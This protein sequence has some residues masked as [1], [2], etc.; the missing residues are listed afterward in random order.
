MVSAQRE[1]P[2]RLEPA[3]EKAVTVAARTVAE[4]CGVRGLARVDF[5][6][7][8]DELFINEINTIPG[9]LTK[10]LWEAP[11]PKLLADML[12]EAVT[13]P[14][15]RYDA[16]GADGLALRSAATIASKLG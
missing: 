6:L 8:G 12:E 3:V 13:R 9:S 10:Y 7:D 2:A 16:T 5:L 4:V 11:F 15:C 1:L 14:S